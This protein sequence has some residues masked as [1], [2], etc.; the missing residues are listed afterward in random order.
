MAVGPMVLAA[1]QAAEP[2]RISYAQEVQPI[3]AARCVSCHGSKSPSEGLDLSS[4]VGIRRGSAGGPVLVPGDIDR[5]RLLSVIAPHAGRATMPPGR[6]LGSE[7]I[8]TLREWIRQGASWAETPP[9]R[10]R[11]PQVVAKEWVRNPIDAFVLYRLEHEALAPSPQADRTTLFRRLSLAITGA[12]P[13]AQQLARF[14]ND[15]R[16]DAYDRFVESLL[17]KQRPDP[18]ATAQWAATKG[19]PMGRRMEV[20]RVWAR[21]FGKGLAEGFEYPAKPPSNPDLLDWL[22]AESLSADWDLKALRRVIVTSATYRQSVR[23]NP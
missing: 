20:N 6:P 5:S 19:D 7:Q 4:L 21:L 3:F 9:V 23:P 17:E 22:T 13:T 14:V 15:R 2:R 12:S 1:W 8:E 18:A 10:L 11:V 16:P